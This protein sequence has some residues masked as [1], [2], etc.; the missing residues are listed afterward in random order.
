LERSPP[1]VDQPRIAFLNL[2]GESCAAI[3]AEDRAVI[4]ELFGRD[5]Q[6]ATASVPCDVLFL[7]CCFEPS[8]K[9][10]GQQASL[11]GLIRDS[12]AQVVVV[13]SE[14]PA[15][16]LSNRKFQAAFAKGDNPPVNLVV[17][18]NRNGDHFGRFFRSLFQMMWSGVSMPRAWVQ[19]APQSPA[20]R[21]DIPS[22]I[23]LMEAGQ[24]TFVP[25]RP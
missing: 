7:Y 18:L 11:R 9:I 20:Q 2:A 8:G 21:D 24:V 14:V 6:D 17:T 1:V 3:V 16:Y 12:T 4:G 5:V 25:T 10:V 22:T 23:C 15:S 19:L 13:A